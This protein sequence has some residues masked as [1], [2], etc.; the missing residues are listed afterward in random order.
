MKPVIGSLVVTALLLTIASSVVS[1]SN[2][3]GLR[4]ASYQGLQG[5]FSDHTRAD[6]TNYGF[7]T[8]GNCTDAESCGNEWIVKVYEGPNC[9]GSFN[10][11]K[12]SNTSGATSCTKTNDNASEARVCD[13]SLYGMGFFGRKTFTDSETCISAHSAFVGWHLGSCTNSAE[14]VLS[15]AFSYA[16]FCSFSDASNSTPSSSYPVSGGAAIPSTSPCPNGASTCDAV[17]SLTYYPSS[18]TCSGSGSLQPA[19]ENA[20]VNTCYSY[21]GGVN[22]KMTCLEDALVIGTYGKNCELSTMTAVNAY[23]TDFCLNL[24]AGIKYQCKASSASNT[25]AS[26]GLIIAIALFFL[27][28]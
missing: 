18:T 24:G 11:V 23:S 26:L 7:E 21:D 6:G 5:S 12:T 8:F 15:S 27:A 3:D 9:Q 25:E 10:Y 17:P 1:S 22:L 4:I 20:K 19:I 2:F 16:P 28:L 14:D 13:R